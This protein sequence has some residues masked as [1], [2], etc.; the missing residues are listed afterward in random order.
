MKRRYARRGEV[1]RWRV[2]L[3]AKVID[4]GD[5][6]QPRIRRSMRRMTGGAALG[7]DWRVLIDPRTGG[8]DVALGA[9]GIL[10]RADAKLVRLERAMGIMAVAAGDQP[11]VH[12]VMEGLGKGSL[13]VRMTAIAKFGLRNLEQ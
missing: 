12:L 5:V 9:D 6:E 4:V 11:F 13:D 8:L 7:L 2:A 1:H 10:G 3:K